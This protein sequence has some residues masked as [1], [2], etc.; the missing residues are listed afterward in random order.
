[1]SSAMRALICTPGAGP[2]I[3][4]RLGG[5]GE[6]VSRSARGVNAPGG[7][8]GIVLSAGV[9]LA[10]AVGRAG[11]SVAAASA[12]L[13]PHCASHCSQ[14]L[15]AAVTDAGLMISAATAM[16]TAHHKRRGEFGTKDS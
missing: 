11:L 15:G 16:A 10:L 7:I 4:V 3:G 8:D 12:S 6:I 9:V 14:R 13:V 2:L 5:S 1:G